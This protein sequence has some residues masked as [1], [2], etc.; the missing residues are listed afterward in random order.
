MEIEI[1]LIWYLISSVGRGSNLDFIFLRIFIIFFK[2]V[3]R[4]ILESFKK[5]RQTEELKRKE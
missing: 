1:H 2:T 3:Y 5:W 4:V